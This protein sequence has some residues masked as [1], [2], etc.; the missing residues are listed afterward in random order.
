VA[1]LQSE[2]R[3]TFLITGNSFSSNTGSNN[4]GFCSNAGGTITGTCS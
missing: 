3:A 1:F 4:Y 2:G